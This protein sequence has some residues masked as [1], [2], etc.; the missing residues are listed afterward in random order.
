VNTV[1]I[2]RLK[3]F[4]S[5]RQR[6]FFEHMSLILGGP[7]G[8][9]FKREVKEAAEFGSAFHMALER[10]AHSPEEV[11]LAIKVGQSYLEQKADEAYNLGNTEAMNRLLYGTGGPERECKKCEGTGLTKVKKQKHKDCNGTGRFKPATSEGVEYLDPFVRGYLE[12][13]PIATHD[14]ESI[15]IERELTLPLETGDQAVGRV[16]RVV[17]WNGSYYHRNYKTLYKSASLGLEAR[18][19]ELDW[20][21]IAYWPM[22]DLEL[23]AGQCKGSF[24]DL[25]QKTQT[26]RYE[27]VPVWRRAALVDKG[28]ADITQLSSDFH[29][30]RAAHCKSTSAVLPGVV[31]SSPRCVHF[32]KLCPY[33]GICTF[34]VPFEKQALEVEGFVPKEEDYVD[35]FEE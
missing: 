7:G 14:E 35:Q 31:R 24:I 10:I 25:A 23:G 8:F 17:K 28:I 33:H 2:S 3:T 1:N 19:Y 29:Q 4:D 27:R 26:P 5:C 34:Q 15:F 32:N 6:S 13:Y 21:E 18:K 22:I 12:K 30:M 9:V 20:H 11:D 16:D